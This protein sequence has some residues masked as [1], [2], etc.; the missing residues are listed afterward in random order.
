MAEL[1]GGVGQSSADVVCL[2]VWIIGED[3]FVRDTAGEQFQDI[4]DADA[5]AADARA[6][7]ALG[8]IDG[9]AFEEC[10]G[11]KVRWQRGKVKAEGGSG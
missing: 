7:V 3:G 10:H 2:E 6:T 5:H 8:G 1:R 9:D 4:G 11:A